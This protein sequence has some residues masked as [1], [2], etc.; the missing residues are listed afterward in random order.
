[1]FALYSQLGRCCTQEGSN[2]LRIKRKKKL[3]CNY[4]VRGTVFKLPQPTSSARGKLKIKLK[5]ELKV[6]Q[7][8]PSM[9]L[10]PWEK[11][12]RCPLQVAQATG[13]PYTTIA[14]GSM[15]SSK[16]DLVEDILQYLHCWQWGGLLA[17]CSVSLRAELS[18]WWELSSACSGKGF[19]QMALTIAESRKRT[20]SHSRFHS[21]INIAKA[22][23]N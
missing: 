7:I 6:H 19:T 14:C 17:L 3:G 18:P 10:L 11:C 23:I 13:I 2:T 9:L 5:I 20:P 22:L 1:M 15:N 4:A 16:S 12:S 21:D 8:S